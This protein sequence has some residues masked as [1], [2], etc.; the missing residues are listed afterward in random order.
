MSKLTGNPIKDVYFCS[1]LRRGASIH[2]YSVCLSDGVYFRYKALLLVARVPLFIRES[3]QNLSRQKKTKKPKKNRQLREKREPL[4][5][6]P[7]W[8]VFSPW[9]SI[10][11]DGLLQRP[12]V[13]MDIAWQS[14]AE[15]RRGALCSLRES[16][17]FGFFSSSSSSSDLFFTTEPG[18]L[19]RQT[20]PGRLVLLWQQPLSPPTGDVRIA[21]THLKRAGAAR[22]AVLVGSSMKTGPSVPLAIKLVWFSGQKVSHSC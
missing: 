22:G 5:M 19:C 18:L 7:F 13:S 8:C 20:H 9:R 2:H 4:Q 15:H 17:C 16:H 21:A 10:Q 12:V 6:S 1:R 3:R 14:E 11:H